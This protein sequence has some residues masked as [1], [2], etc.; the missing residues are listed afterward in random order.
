[1]N[2][3]TE[4]APLLAAAAPVLM[5]AVINVCLALQGERDTL[6][7]PSVRSF[8]TATAGAVAGL[9]T[10]EPVPIA[11]FEP[12]NDEMARKAA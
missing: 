12:A 6:L 4:F 11:S 5:I 7:F 3:F 1:M 10:T 9:P 2:V 8:P